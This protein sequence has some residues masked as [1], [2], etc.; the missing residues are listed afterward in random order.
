MYG[1]IGN[2]HIYSFWEAHMFTY[3]SPNALKIVQSDWSPSGLGSF[4]FSTDLT[5]KGLSK[6]IADLHAVASR[7][8]INPI[9]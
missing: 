1:G 7:I 6:N 9:P 2:H 4:L 5:S 8:N 3:G